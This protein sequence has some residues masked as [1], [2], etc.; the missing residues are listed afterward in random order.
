MGTVL[1]KLFSYI[2]FNI[3]VTYKRGSKCCVYFFLN[4][5]VFLVVQ[6]GYS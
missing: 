4:M 3:F 5:L 1:F 2:L 6:G